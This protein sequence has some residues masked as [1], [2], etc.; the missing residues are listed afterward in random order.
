LYERER[1][2]ELLETGITGIDYEPVTRDELPKAGFRWPNKAHWLNYHIPRIFSDETTD[3]LGEE[4]AE[5]VATTLAQLGADNQF[6]ARTIM[7]TPCGRTIQEHPNRLPGLLLEADQVR[8]RAQGDYNDDQDEAPAAD[9][10]NDAAEAKPAKPHVLLP[11]GVVLE[12]QGPPPRPESFAATAFTAARLK[13]KVF[14]PVEYIVADFIAEGLTLF[15]GKPKIGKSWLLL[16]AAAAVANGRTTLG[17]LSCVQGDVLYA[18]LED[19][20]RR[21]QRRLTK[22]GGPFPANLTFTCEMPRLADGGL[23][24][25][26][27]WIKSAQ[28][29][30]LVIIDT[31][32]MVRSPAR[33]DQTAYEADYERVRTLRDLAA[34][35]HL[36]IIIVHHL[37]K[38][39]A[40]DALD[41]VSGTLGLTG[42]PDT[43][44]II[45]RE[46]SGV[47]LTAQGR[48]IE[49]VKKAVDFNPTVAMWTITGDA[50]EVRR[51][52]ERNT[53]IKAFREANGEPL[54]PKQIAENTDM[55]GGAVRTQLQ[56]MKAAGLV[57]TAKY[58]KYVLVRETPEHIVTLGK[59]IGAEQAKPGWG[60]S[61]LDEVNEGL[62]QSSSSEGKSKPRNPR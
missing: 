44:M 19:N 48:D 16:H 14:Q 54:G 38:A 21:L 23:Q 34:E 51:S 33:K 40:D 13:D 62:A 37:R 57:K 32:A 31:L 61:D 1:R 15:A 49:E 36:A 24:Y 26:K 30:K 18:A 9:N 42:C 27:D 53:I 52:V 12:D 25:I 47:T 29:P 56:R 22:L 6:I 7:T 8:R 39:E 28:R 43:I 41:T 10:D 20:Q 60:K 46:G 55:R 50:D 45:R 2:D 3:S 5:Y 4:I 17:T 35:H 58:G 59:V 11:G